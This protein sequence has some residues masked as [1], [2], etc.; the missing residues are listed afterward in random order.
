MR[1]FN[2]LIL[3][4][5]VAGWGIAACA[6]DAP[7]ADQ[8]RIVFIA[9]RPSHGWGQ[10]EHKA[11]CMLLAWYLNNNV[12]QVKADVYVNG[13][14]KEP[15]ALD[16]A[17]AVIIYADG[18]D[19]HPAIPHLQE[20]DALARK[21]VGIG[22]IHYAVEVPKDKAGKEFLDWT[23]GYFETFW[24]VNPHWL[25]EFKTIPNHAVT[26]GVKPFATQDEWY[27]N[28]R[29]REDMKGVT[30]ILTAVPPDSTRQ[31]KDDAH[32]GNKF[33]REN[34]GR[35]ETVLWVSENEG[36]GRG[37]G[38]TGGHFHK[39]WAND[40]FRTTVLNCIVWIAKIEVPANGVPTKRPDADELLKD[41]DPKQP[42]KDFTKEGFAKEL[43]KINQP[44]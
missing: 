5:V 35:P 33:V 20:L 28:M 21:G 3:A 30:P 23:G 39:N 44:K 12:P 42:P 29:F 31:G 32:G 27:Y 7:A 16:G 24:S 18:G 14:P 26:R 2:G 43:D 38:C 1:W 40:D 17:A 25:G 13:W 10:H 36:G 41:Q 8:K 22:M 9:G 11:G 19:G 37:F 4:A 15:N 6:A 34:K